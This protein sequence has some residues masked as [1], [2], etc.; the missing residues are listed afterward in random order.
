MITIGHDESLLSVAVFGEFTLADYKE[1]E[2]EVNYKIRFEG[3]VDVLF[4]FR[5]MMGFTLDVAWEEVKFAREHA[6]DFGRVAV[7][8]SDQ[9]LTWSAWISQLFVDAQI[10]VFDQEDDARLWLRA[11]AGAGA[12]AGAER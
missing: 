1:F 8:T 5:E 10:M 2:E 7:L 6:H 3:K 9:W 12:G 4:D 11:E